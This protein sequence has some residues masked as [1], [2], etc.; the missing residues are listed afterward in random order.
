MGHFVDV[1][2]Y[3]CFN[4]SR[5]SIDAKFSSVFHFL[6]MRIMHLMSY[7]KLSGGWCPSSLQGKKIHSLLNSALFWPLGTSQE[8][9]MVCSWKHQWSS[10]SAAVPSL[11]CLFDCLYS[12]GP[13]AY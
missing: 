5:Y 1:F 6:K 12:S 9:G 4:R 11:P 2:L 10:E 7:Q 8:Q 3:K 13:I